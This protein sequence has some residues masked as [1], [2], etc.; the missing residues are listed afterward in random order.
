VL[1]INL[2]PNRFVIAGEYRITALKIDCISRIVDLG[3]DN[4]MGSFVVAKGEGDHFKIADGSIDICVCEFDTDYNSVQIG[5]GAEDNT[6]I[7]RDA[8]RI[9]KL[10]EH[11]FLYEANM[12][13]RRLG[14][15]EDRD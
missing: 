14:F 1:H 8:L 12:W 9:R 2:R 6:V 5:I 13:R 7:D 4:N 15:K 10:K 3:I 11:G